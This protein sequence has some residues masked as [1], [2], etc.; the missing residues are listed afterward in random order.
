MWSQLESMHLVIPSKD[1]QSSWIFIVACA[2]AAMREK[3]CV[4]LCECVLRERERESVFAYVWERE[5][6]RVCVWE[7]EKERECVLVRVRE[8][9]GVRRSWPS[10]QIY[11][12]SWWELLYLVFLC[13]IQ[14]RLELC[15]S[16]NPDFFV[17]DFLSASKSCFWSSAG[18]LNRTR[19]SW[20]NKALVFHLDKLTLK[21]TGT[22]P[23]K[24]IHLWIKWSKM[25]AVFL[26]YRL[27]T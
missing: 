12:S 26:W 19:E 14:K 22:D 18:I 6:V 21:Y 9:G 24:G 15:S 20:I 16:P 8:R 1:W 3:E 7:R 17:Q 13:S 2:A 10:L 23:C 5:C 25:V 11:S 27:N 4:Y